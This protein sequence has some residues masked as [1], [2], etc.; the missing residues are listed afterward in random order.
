[1]QQALDALKLVYEQADFSNG[2]TDPTGT[3]DEGKVVIGG[4]VSDA[5]A[6]LESELAK[7][8]QEPYC[9]VQSKLNQGLFFKEKP[10]RIHTIPLYTA[11]L[12]KSEQIITPISIDQYERIC[13]NCG[14]CVGKRWVGLNAKDL[15][16]IPPSCF[17]GAIWA[18][19]KLKEKNT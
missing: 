18:D 10:R 19:G 15:S 11:P 4:I 14:A 13:F 17:E 6:A 12:R 3:M 16:E 1:M 7:P 2:V 9:W 5:I 8:N